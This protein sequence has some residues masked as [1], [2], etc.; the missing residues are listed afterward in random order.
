MSVSFGQV[1]GNTGAT[2][3]TGDAG[4]IGPTGPTGPRQY[5]PYVNVN[6]DG[7]ASKVDI[8][9][10]RFNLFKVCRSTDSNSSGTK[11]LTARDDYFDPDV[12]T[13]MAAPYSGYTFLC[14]VCFEY[15]QTTP[16][17]IYLNYRYNNNGTISN[18]SATLYINGAATSAS[19]PFLWAAGSLI[20][21]AIQSTRAYFV[22]YLGNYN[23]TTKSVQ[24]SPFYSFATAPAEADLPIRP[25]F[26][27]VESDN[28]WYYCDGLA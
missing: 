24:T 10:I 22:S 15:G 1:V 27:H 16:L 21:F 25:C 28:G 7:I 8:K 6:R 17:P 5:Y 11:Y 20:L 26:Y 13:T 18:R 23:V 3:A 9:K 12:N 14:Y 2:G 19:N 4:P